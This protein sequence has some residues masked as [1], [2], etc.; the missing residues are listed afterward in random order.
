VT[1]AEADFSELMAL[2]ADL[3][4]VAKESPKKARQ[5]VQQTGIRTKAQWAKDASG[6]PLGRQYT[7]TIDYTLT[8]AVSGGI[9]D[10]EMGPNL[11]RYGG[12]TGPGGLVPSA[13]I[14]DDPLRQGGILTPPDRSRRKAEKFAAEDIE[15]GISIALDQILTERGL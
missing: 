14:F 6:N 8:G 13:G 12:K 2:A 4:A 7:A 9:L 15:K 3:T 10:L 5:A 1:R 11:A